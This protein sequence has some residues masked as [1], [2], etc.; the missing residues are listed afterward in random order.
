MFFL[1]FYFVAYLNSSQH[2]LCPFTKFPLFLKTFF[3]FSLPPSEVEPLS[4]FPDKN[5][6]NLTC[7]IHFFY[8]LVEYRARKEGYPMRLEVVKLAT[9]Q[10]EWFLNHRASTSI[11]LILIE[12]Y[13][14]YFFFFKFTNVIC[15]WQRP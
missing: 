15:K 9:A 1:S 8:I 6:E 3:T 11:L 10:K 13:F 7:K 12:N 2:Q 5:S 4:L 14:R